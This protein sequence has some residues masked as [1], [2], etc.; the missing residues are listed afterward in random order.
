MD[1]VFFSAFTMAI[2]LKEHQ[3]E[4]KDKCDQKKKAPTNRGSK[5][6]GVLSYCVYRAVVEN[7][8]QFTTEESFLRDISISAWRDRHGQNSECERS[9][10]GGFADARA[11]LSS[12]KVG[13]PIMEVVRLCC[14]ELCKEVKFKRKIMGK[15]PGF[16]RASLTERCAEIAKRINPVTISEH[17]PHALGA[18]VIYMAGQELGMDVFSH[19]LAPVITLEKCSCYIKVSPELV[20]SHIQKIFMKRPESK[21]HDMVF[22]IEHPYKRLKRADPVLTLEVVSDYLKTL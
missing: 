9:I 5:R 2:E 1:S 10:K 20:T 7:T 3:Y 8:F 16:W 17:K 11:R 12:G 21:T 19:P 22:A 18:A 6:W 13:C 4:E 14:T 15:H